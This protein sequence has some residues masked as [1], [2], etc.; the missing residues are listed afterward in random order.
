MKKN[1]LSRLSAHQKYP[2]KLNN[3]NTFT[4]KQQTRYK[5]PLAL[6]LLAFSIQYLLYLL[7]CLYNDFQF[8]FFF[9]LVLIRR[10]SI[11]LFD[12]KININTTNSIEAHIQHSGLSTERPPMAFKNLHQF[13]VLYT[14][15][16]ANQLINLNYRIYHCE[17]A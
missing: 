1:H 12:L 14:C 7:L 15:I 9:V 13:Q 10:L 4:N 6:L 17:I 5:C 8:F 11:F 2:M 3:L 16:H